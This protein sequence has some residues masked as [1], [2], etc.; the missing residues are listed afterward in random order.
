MN[1]GLPAARAPAT[2]R[3]CD[4]LYFHP[5]VDEAAPVA[6]ARRKYPISLNRE[7]AV[8][9]P[10]VQTSAPAPPALAQTP[11][12]APRREPPP[13]RAGRS[14]IRKALPWLIAAGVIGMLFLAMRPKPLPVEVAAASRGP[15]EV[16][17]L[18]EGK[19]RIRHRYTISPPLGGLLERIDFRAGARIKEGETL[20]LIRPEPANLLNPRTQSE[21]EARVNGAG[22]LLKEREAEI[23]RAQ[24]AGELADRDKKRAE[25]L[26]SSGAISAK[27]WD[28]AELNAS[29]RQ[30][31]LHG[32]EFA[33][34]VA[35]FE[36]KQAEAALLQAE[37]KMEGGS[38]PFKILSPLSGVVLN[39]FEES[40]R[41]IT[42]GTPI[43][44]VGD[45]TDLEAEIEL[46]STDAAGVKPGVRATIERWGGD[47]PLPAT[48]SLVEPA[49]FTKISA[50]GVEEQRVKVRVEFEGGLPQNEVLGDRYR[51][52]AR[53][54]IWNA[55]DVLQ[56]P[57]GALFR[58][59]GDWMCYTLE[60]RRATLRKVTIGHNNGI[61]AEVL[62]GI[63][64]GERVI[65]HPPDAVVAGAVVTPRQEPE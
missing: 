28:A 42:P 17:V 59:G 55:P 3:P 14:R 26:Y 46:L 19:T 25:P 57:S 13:K 29:M 24:A 44:E 27:E 33:L 48:V 18:E 22:A 36:L 47:R 63:S 53:I 21:A 6:D 61:S 8:S 38:E 11:A 34:Q 64:A 41:L 30:R 49:A 50:L 51:V 58:R 23:E 54:V 35:K 12:S 5:G 10:S 39:V 52:E 7:P 62:G 2:P 65:L 32:A 4:R 45:P 40:T 20:A 15:M 60:N 37:G 56:I 31:E 9:S 1:G 16:S 43:L